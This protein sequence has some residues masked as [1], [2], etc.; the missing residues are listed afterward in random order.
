MERT[1]PENVLFCFENTGVY[2]LAL[3]VFMQENQ[4]AYSCVAG[5][6]INRSMGITIGNTLI[7]EHPPFPVYYLVYSMAPFPVA[8]IINQILFLPH[9]LLHTLSLGNIVRLN[10]LGPQLFDTI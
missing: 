10:L 5:L 1:D 8:R 9:D 2:S 6:E 3:S 7:F 4:L